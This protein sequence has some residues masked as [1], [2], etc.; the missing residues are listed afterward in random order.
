M[1]SYR[2]RLKRIKEV[3]SWLERETA[4][5]VK[6]MMVEIV[7]KVVGDIDHH[8]LIKTLRKKYGKKR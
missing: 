7:C 2:A 5:N 1:K 4:R 3:T 8:P 6:L